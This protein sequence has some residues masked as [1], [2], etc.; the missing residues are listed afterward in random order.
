MSARSQGSFM[1]SASK[2]ESRILG[3]SNN[4]EFTIAFMAPEGAGDLVFRTKGQGASHC[5]GEGFFATMVPTV[6]LNAA[7]VG[8][9]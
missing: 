3:E 1:V 6:M 8:V 9:F 4:E 7:A 5:G 2:E